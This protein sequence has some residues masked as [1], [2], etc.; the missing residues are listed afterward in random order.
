MPCICKQCVGF[1]EVL[2]INFCTSLQNKLACDDG[3]PLLGS[4]VTWVVAQCEFIV[5]ARIIV[6][7]CDEQ[8]FLESGVGLFQDIT[9]TLIAQ[10]GAEFAFHSIDFGR[11]GDRDRPCVVKSIARIFKPGLANAGASFIQ[12]ATQLH[13]SKLRIEER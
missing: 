13:L 11:I 9:N 3:K 7:W 12:V 4:G 5:I 8:T 1:V 10:R 2:H 6:R